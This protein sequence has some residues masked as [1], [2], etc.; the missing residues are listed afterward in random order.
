MI[1]IDNIYL[2][3]GFPDQNGE[4]G[5]AK[6]F[7]DDNSVQYVHLHYADPRQWQ[8]VFDAFGTWEAYDSDGD[9]KFDSSRMVKANVFAFPILHYDVIT[10]DYKRERVV[11]QGAQNILNS[12]VVELSKVNNGG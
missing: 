2:S 9:G 4:G 11:I 8:S 12:R 6:K 3:T 7:L 10:E 1:K 5:I